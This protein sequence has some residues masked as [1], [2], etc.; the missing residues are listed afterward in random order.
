MAR[1]QNDRYHVGK[2]VLDSFFMIIKFY[3]SVFYEP[4]SWESVYNEIAAVDKILEEDKKIETSFS[5]SDDSVE[6]SISELVAGLLGTRVVRVVTTHS[7]PIFETKI[8]ICTIIFFFLLPRTMISGVVF[9]EFR[10]KILRKLTSAGQYPLG[11]ARNS[12]QRFWN[13]IQLP[14]LRNFYRF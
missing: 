1:E 14:V 9:H 12:S 5:W 10:A 13:W 3:L 7:F 4:L 2:F 8:R 11:N 6:L